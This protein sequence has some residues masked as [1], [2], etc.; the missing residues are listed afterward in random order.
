M[1]ILLVDS[2]LTKNWMLSYMY[3]AI[4]DK[5]NLQLPTFAGIPKSQKILHTNKRKV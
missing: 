4:T 3:A 1:K 5:D 2:D